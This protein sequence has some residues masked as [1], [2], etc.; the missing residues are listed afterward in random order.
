MNTTAIIISITMCLIGLTVSLIT[1]VKAFSTA[2]KSAEDKISK[3][4]ENYQRNL[5]AVKH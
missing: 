4:R 1:I 3:N 2:K 5:H